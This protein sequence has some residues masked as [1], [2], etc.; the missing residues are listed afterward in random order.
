MDRRL[1]SGAQPSDERESRQY[2]DPSTILDHEQWKMLVIHK[3]LPLSVAVIEEA[4]LSL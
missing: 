2:N 1:L 3:M 4:L